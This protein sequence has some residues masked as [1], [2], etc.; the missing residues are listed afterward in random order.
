MASPRSPVGRGLGPK[1]KGIVNM[2]P[3]MRRQILQAL[4]TRWIGSL[5][6]LTANERTKLGEWSRTFIPR[7]VTCGYRH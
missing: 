2:S 1:M 6:A 3:L 4:E 5:V 7:L